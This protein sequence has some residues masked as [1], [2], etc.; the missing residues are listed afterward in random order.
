MAAVDTFEWYVSTMLQDAPPEVQQFIRAQRASL[1]T[2]R[3]EDE[4]QRFVED[5]MLELRRRCSPGAAHG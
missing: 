2:L 4:Q 1:L 3:S 5:V